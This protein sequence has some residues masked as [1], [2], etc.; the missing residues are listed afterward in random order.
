M[1]ETE[2]RARLAENIGQL[3]IKV[4]SIFGAFYLYLQVEESKALLPLLET[5]IF[6]NYF[7]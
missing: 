4:Y 2:G 1:R 5:Q 7:Q 6:L 3:G